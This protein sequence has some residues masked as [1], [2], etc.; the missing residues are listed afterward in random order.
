MGE[1]LFWFVMLKGEK[2]IMAEK[3]SA[4]ITSRTDS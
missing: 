3:Q 2:S 1:F 4:E